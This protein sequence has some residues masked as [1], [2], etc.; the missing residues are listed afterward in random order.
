MTL[1]HETKPSPDDLIQ[2]GRDDALGRLHE[3]AQQRG[4]ARDGRALRALQRLVDACG[5]QAS[6]TNDGNKENENG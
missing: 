1:D 4:R 6:Y 2:H 5:L 3:A